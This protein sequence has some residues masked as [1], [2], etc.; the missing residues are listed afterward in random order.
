MIW[1]WDGSIVIGWFCFVLVPQERSSFI[2]FQLWNVFVL[3][4][5]LKVFSMAQ[6][7][8]SGGTALFSS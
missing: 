4:Q 8:S 3:F 2:I 1:L 6:L 5:H 7:Y